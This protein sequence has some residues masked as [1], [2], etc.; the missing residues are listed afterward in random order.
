M[1]MHG[2]PSRVLLEISLVTVTAPKRLDKNIQ[3][4][5]AYVENKTS[6]VTWCLGLLPDTKS[7]DF[8]Q[9]L[10]QP[11]SAPRHS[12][13]P[14]PHFFVPRLLRPSRLPMTFLS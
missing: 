2:T 8:P 6:L 7:H 10:S 1:A 14:G 5:R 3:E 4:I 12:G 11:G 9:A 13:S